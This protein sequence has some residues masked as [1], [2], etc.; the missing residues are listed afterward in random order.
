MPVSRLQ[1][2]AV[3][4]AAAAGAGAGAGA[5]VGAVGGGSG[6]LRKLPGRAGANSGY[7]E[8]KML[9]VQAWAEEVGAISFGDGGTVSPASRG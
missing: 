2:A 1:G 5:V 4:A 7:T 6:G 9:T 8:S 3:W